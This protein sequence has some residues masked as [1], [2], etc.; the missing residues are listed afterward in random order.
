MIGNGLILI[1][2]KQI[3]EISKVV[4]EEE[5]IKNCMCVDNMIITCLNIISK[6]HPCQHT[7]NTYNTHTQ[8]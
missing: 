8:K 2:W 7:Y 1:E 3:H 4:M 5:D 6:I